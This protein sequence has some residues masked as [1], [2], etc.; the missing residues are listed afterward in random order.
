MKVGITEANDPLF[1]RSW[2]R[3]ALTERQPTILI[4]KNI[5]LLLER[6][7]NMLTQQN[8]LV[9]ATITGYGGTFMEPGVPKPAETLAALSSIKS[10]ERVVIRIDP[11]IPLAQFVKQSQSVFT[12]CTDMGYKR[13]RI[14]VMD[15]YPHV[16]KRL[17]AYHSLSYDLKQMY[18]WDLS[19]ALGEH[20]DYMVHAPLQF[21]QQIV[22]L[23]PGANCC[24]EPG[25]PC[26]EG[27]VSRTDL[28]L[29]GIHPEQRYVK[30]QQRPFCMC[31]G[32]KKELCRHHVCEGNCLYC[33][34]SKKE[35]DVKL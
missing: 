29:M 34:W 9:H 2:E 23:F 25:I 7:P 24:G 14:S 10:K 21:R 26:T 11:I 6:Y 15:L 12:R 17:E 3:W 18:Q 8:I 5:K 32:I 19:H 27:C 33:F 22:D 13:F 31:L 20:K 4:T 1:D 35:E 28:E 30:N 16:L